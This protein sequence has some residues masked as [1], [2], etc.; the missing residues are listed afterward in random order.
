MEWSVS[1]ARKRVKAMV[2]EARRAMPRKALMGALLRH[3]GA[4][5]T[6]IPGGCRGQG[7]MR[8]ARRRT[9][10]TTTRTLTINAPDPG[11]YS[12]P[13]RFRDERIPG[14]VDE[15]IPRRAHGAC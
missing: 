2:P 3:A 11:G 12:H 10:S 13:A 1:R 6:S 9:G 8:G 14:F 5:G 15:R 4:N 7:R